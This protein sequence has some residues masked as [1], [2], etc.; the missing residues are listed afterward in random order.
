MKKALLAFIISTSFSAYAQQSKLIK[1]AG[2]L[3]ESKAYYEAIEAYKLGLKSN[4]KNVDG[5]YKLA[6]SYFK[7][8][9][10]DQARQE[11]LKL[12]SL[13]ESDKE[14]T[15]EYA[16]A[17]YFYALVLKADE[18]YDEAKA[19][20]L[21]FIKIKSH[22]EGM[23]EYKRLANN[24]VRSC[25]FAIDQKAVQYYRSFNVEKLQGKI[26]SAYSEFSPRY[27][28]GDAIVFSSLYSNRLLQ[29]HPEETEKPL[30][31]IYVSHLRKDVAVDIEEFQNFNDDFF[32]TA[33]GSFTPDKKTFF[34]TYCSENRN[35]ATSC[36]IYRSD[37]IGKNW[38]KPEKLKSDI[39]LPG[40]TSTQPC[41]GVVKY[42]SRSFSA[43]YF[44]SDRPGGRGG[45]DIWFAEAEGKNFSKPENCGSRINSPGN[46]ISPFFNSAEKTMYFS[47]DYWWGMGGYDVFKAEGFKKSWKSPENLGFPINSSYDD[48]YY[49]FDDKVQK[50]LLSSNRP[51]GNPVNDET[52]CE[53]I[54]IVTENPVEQLAGMVKDADS[55][56]VILPET[57]VGYYL[58]NSGERDEIN[59]V[60][61]SNEEGKFIFIREL[62]KSYRLILDK[63]GY[64]L[65]SFDLDSALHHKPDS[66]VFVFYLQKKPQEKI[67]E[68]PLEST[69]Q[70]LAK[71]NR[72][73]FADKIDE[74]ETQKGDVFI[75]DNL[76]FE[77]NKSDVK[78]ELH[79]E[80]DALYNFLSTNPQIRI[81]ISGHTDSWGSDE[82]NLQLSQRRAEV[83]K[84]YLIEKGIDEDR[85][86]ATGYG[87][88]MPIADN[89]T[90]EGRE[91]N[92][93]T[94]IKIL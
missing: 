64:K 38:T 76:H 77:F 60:L 70:L 35:G 22:K 79:K 68:Q 91:L 52:C 75:L 10:Y 39:N 4:P 2:S 32:H 20:F 50:G 21:K 69:E 16:M 44:V 48:T 17:W 12:I 24:E 67:K 74:K 28:T 46:E 90:D 94:E 34:F 29:A 57:H 78:E 89:E 63:P 25:N 66:G 41:F 37:R 86:M 80:L 42:G 83:V 30:I 40:S 62:K 59:W 58:K 71:A 84:Q 93:R 87:E 43:L 56:E 7:I 9:Q 14:Q 26:N 1:E 51:G 53:D 36:D 73:I 61:E 3:F 33:N 15:G 81:E 55:T 13:V 72:E 6:L 23:R 82:Y 65:S 5:R 54:Y 49:S 27:F 85:L 19:N 45:L 47:S 8:R 88:K 31:K 92:R 11:F 18:Q